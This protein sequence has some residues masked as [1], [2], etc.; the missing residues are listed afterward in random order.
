MELI[1]YLV[2]FAI[3]GISVI[4]ESSG[5]D[6][7]NGGCYEDK[8]PRM[9]TGKV[10]KNLP[11]NSPN[12]CNSFCKGFK[13]YAVQYTR[14]CFC[15]DTL[16]HSVKKPEKECNA[17]CPGDSSKKCGGSWRQNLYKTSP[18]GWY[19]GDPEANCDATCQKNGLVCTEN[20]MKAHNG[21]VDSPEKVLS[22]IKSLGEEFTATS[23]WGDQGYPDTPLFTKQ[24]NNGYGKPFCL[25]SSPNK[26]VSCSFNPG[27]DNDNEGKQRLCYCNKG[28]VPLYRYW[29]N[30]DHFY[31]TNE[32]EIGT[33]TPGKT[34]NHGYKSEGIACKVFTHADAGSVPLYRYWKSNGVDHFYTTNGNEIGTTTPGKTGKYGYKSEG[35]AGYCF[36]NQVAGTVPLHRYW[37]PTI[38]DHFYTTNWGELGRGKKG[39]G[40]EGV[41]CY[42]F[43]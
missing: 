5:A 23:C 2:V 7:V 25:S 1:K 31:T 41:Q 22:L 39:W 37:N 6:I 16:H 17:V 29:G 12:A 18:E 9:L 21:E 26:D 33:T 30:S 14:E 19:I 27:G 38:T 3:L 35:I 10:E 20:V 4:T 8:L 15:G 13:Y 32:Q 40:Y 28:G 34:G 42:V 24:S 36:S 11:N 43:P